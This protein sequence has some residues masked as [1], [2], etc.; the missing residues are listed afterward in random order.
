MNGVMLG[1]CDMAQLPLKYVHRY[2][3]RHG[4]LRHYFRQGRGKGTALPGFPGS[5]EFMAAYQTA[6]AGLTQPINVGESKTQPGTIDA[7]VVAYYRSVEWNGLKPTS[8]TGRKPY[9]ERFR[10]ANGQRLIKTLRR[11]HIE[12]MMALIPNLYARTHWLSAIRPLLQFA[13]PTLITVNPTEGIRPPK[14]PK[15]AGWH[16]WTDEEIQQYRDYWNLGTQQRLVF[17]FALEAASRRCEVVRLGPQHVRDGRIKIAR[18][19][20]SKDVDI[21]LTPELKAAIDA[22]PATHLVYVVNRFGKPRSPNGLGE[23][24]AEWATAAGL[25]KRCRLHGLK[26]GGMRRLAESDATTHQIMAVSGHKTLKEVQRYTD[27]ADRRK[28]A[29]QAI[30]KRI[31]NR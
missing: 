15:T 1:R 3:D 19:K 21:L 22:M 18:A 26:K 4:R 24:F 13:V 30:G 20:G 29:D 11:E 23:S 10:E 16:T 17:E 27:A 14:L 2:R 6:L 7:L 9:I 25:P 28:L 12:K 31:K 8:K 5:D